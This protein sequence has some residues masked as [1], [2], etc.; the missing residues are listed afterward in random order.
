MPDWTTLL[1][2]IDEGLASS[3]PVL[4]DFTPSDFGPLPAALAP[5]AAATLQCMAKAEAA[6]ERDLTE[7]GRELTA[8]SAARAA[9]VATA[10]PVP[11]FLDTRA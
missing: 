1:D 7:V 6:L 3:P 2:A 4:V 11:H 5:R 8:L 10:A 9:A